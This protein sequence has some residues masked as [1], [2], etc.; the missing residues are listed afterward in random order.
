MVIFPQRKE[1]VTRV[2]WI[3]VPVYFETPKPLSRA[4]NPP[5][6]NSVKP[7]CDCDGLKE[8]I[9][10]TD[11]V[12][13]PVQVGVV[14]LFMFPESWNLVHLGSQAKLIGPCQ[15][16]RMSVI[17]IVWSLFT[18]T[19]RVHAELFSILKLRAF[20]ALHIPGRTLCEG[21]AVFLF[22]WFVL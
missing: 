11:D 15:Q 10:H 18:H 6:C 4:L 17:W 19:Q 21:L 8:D 3:N 14:V 16:R 7:W 5:V 22:C 13:G 9:K 1:W 20:W 2:H 12:S